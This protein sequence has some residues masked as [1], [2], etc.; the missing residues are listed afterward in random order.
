MD[1]HTRR[2]G[3]GGGGGCACCAAPLPVP[4]PA[5]RRLAVLGAQVKA[6]P[7]PAAGLVVGHAGTARLTVLGAPVKAVPSAG[8]VVGHDGTAELL[9]TQANPRPLPGWAPAQRA[10]HEQLMRRAF[11]LAKMAVDNGNCP[12][13]G[14]LATPVSPDGSGGEIVLEHC[15]GVK[16][17]QG[18]GQY[19]GTPGLPD[20]TDHGETGAIRAASALLPHDQLATL[21]LYT[22][23][24]PC[25]MCS[26]AIF[27]A[28]CPLMIY[29]T[30]GP[31]RGGERRPTNQPTNQ[32]TNHHLSAAAVRAFSPHRIFQLDH[33]FLGLVFVHHCL[34]VFTSR[35]RASCG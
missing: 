8:A 17:K 7:G 23:T 9:W 6:V 35:A 5:H 29:G 12:Y 33:C 27:W 21:T 22:S 20:L 4:V 28:G 3:G 24:E 32:P 2:G 25:A 1:W 34:E 13:A 26:V 30:A 11:A 14:L 10:K 16:G 18:P 15:N 31:A 19:L